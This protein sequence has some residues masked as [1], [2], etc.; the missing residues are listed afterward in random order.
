MFRPALV[1]MLRSGCGRRLTLLSAPTGYGK[2]TLLAQWHKSEH[3]D[4]L[5]AWVSLDEED[6]E[7]L[8]LCARLVEAVDR[9][10]PGCFDRKVRG[11][12]QNP[13]A[14]FNGVVLPGIV[15]ELAELSQ[16]TVIVLDDYHLLKVDFQESL[17]AYLLRSLPTTVQIV[18]STRTEPPVP[19][20]RLRATRELVEIRAADLC[21]GPEE[22][23]A[24]FGVSAET[25]LRDE[26]LEAIRERTE[27]WPAGLYLATLALRT[28][29]H[30]GEDLRAF[31]GS[32]RHVADYLAEE[33]L[34]HQPPGVRSFLL[35]TSILDRFNASLCD[36]VTGQEDSAGMLEWL[37]RSNLFLTPLDGRREWY[38][39]HRLFSDLLQLELKNTA[40]GSVPGLHKRAAAWYQDTGDIEATVRHTLASGD[41]RES[42]A[43]IV[44]HWLDWLRVGWTGTLRSWISSMP[45]EEVAAYPP[46][47]LVNAWL[48]AF[49]GDFAAFGR[50][51]SVAENGK[52]EGRLPDG[53]SSLESGVAVLRSSYSFDGIR[54][55][56]E[57]GRRALELESAPDSPWA[58]LIRALL[59]YNLYWAG[60]PEESKLR[61]E[62]SLCLSRVSPTLPATR[63][64]STGYLSL[65][66][67]EGGNLALA[68]RLAQEALDQTTA[69]G[70]DQTHFAS[71]PRVTLGIVLAS[72]GRQ[73]EAAE[74]FERA[75][76]LV[77]HID[78][79]PAH[80][81]ALLAYAPTRLALG[82]R[83]GAR[84]LLQEAHGLVEGFEDPGLHLLTALDLTKR[85]LR[86]GRRK[87][88][89]GQELSEAEGE[90]LRLLASGL[91]RREIAAALY[92]SV[93][94][95]KSH[96]R[97]AYR[98]L[99]A[100]SREEAVG[101]ARKLG[102]RL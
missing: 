95:V 10:E 88:E 73:E 12:L 50:W 85:K 27:G 36:A 76:E 26:D 29:Q 71:P 38:R 87:S 93:N 84:N 6:Q 56:C 15:K 18:V 9:V 47:A 75:I 1:E 39:Y 37:E 24:M 28:S 82:D 30:S 99:G 86:F 61:L 67:A 60:E 80:P 91:Q 64:I 97:S 51:I 57:A 20:G 48:S 100:S 43:L 34:Q 54:H 92:L 35:Q 62:E 13:G 55:G 3:E 65:V 81:H 2:T 79:N 23:R 40:P 22:T 83:D 17:L 68:E 77:R 59:G 69:H 49:N 33:V 32:T 52:Y 53:T 31:A 90:V 21:F 16:D 41:Y 78:K 45:E 94:T 44:R 66:E 8:R 74:E 7:P 4:R 102:L 96:L 5:F 19:L 98:K 25:R 42:G 72:D 11:L 89:P 46:L 101:R 63:I 14:D 70:F 58:S